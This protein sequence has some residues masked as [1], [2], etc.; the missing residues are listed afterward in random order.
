MSA[1]WKMIV[2]SA[3][4]REALHFLEDVLDNN[5]LVRYVGYSVATAPYTAETR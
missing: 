5:D 1:G 2:P 3:R 4:R